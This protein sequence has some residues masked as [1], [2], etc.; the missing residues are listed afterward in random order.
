[1]TAEDEPAFCSLGGQAFCRRLRNGRQ[2]AGD[3]CS[4]RTASN[5]PEETASHRTGRAADNGARHRTR[6]HIDGIEEDWL[7]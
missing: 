5:T 3:S 1:M 7:V 2:N 6:N 4:T